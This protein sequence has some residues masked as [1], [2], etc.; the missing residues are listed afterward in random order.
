LSGLVCYTALAFLLSEYQCCLLSA[1]ALL[2]VIA[3]STFITDWTEIFVKKTTKIDFG[4][5]EVTEL[6]FSEH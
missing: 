4:V 1:S 5:N 3:F 2:I 6:D